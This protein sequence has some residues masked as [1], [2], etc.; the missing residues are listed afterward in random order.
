MYITITPQKL[1]GS[2]SQSV[3]EFVAYLEKENEDKSVE[4][5]EHFFN[6]HEDVIPSNEVIS[7][8]DKNTYKLKKVEPKFYSLTINPS[9]SELKHLKN[10]SKDLKIYVREIMKDYAASFYRDTPVS[11]NQIKYYAKIEYE[12]TYK[13]MDK[14]IKENAPF[15]G[16]IMQLKNEIQQINSGKLIGNINQK[17]KMIKQLEKNAPHQING[18]MILQGMAKEGSQS[19]IHIIV[20]RMDSMNRNS[21]SPG[22][23]YKASEV[24]FNGIKTK[25]GFDRNKFYTASEKTFDKVFLYNR[26]FTETYKARKA[27]QKNPQKYFA[28]IMG[29]PTNE[30]AIAFKLIGKT[31]M[32][33][34]LLNIPTNQVQL[35]LKVIKKFKK[36]VDIALKSGS[37]GI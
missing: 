30:R 14:A 37:I 11:V 22:S 12:R 8:I 26:N 29:L 13:G 10:H 16:K 28:S 20:S 34:S 1:T 35:A 25:R 4:D 19:H 18:Q 3:A 31:G 27:F 9:A 5:L 23:T 7:E 36:G 21:L 15:H 17:V 6:Q 24:V 33:T 32:N 2:Y